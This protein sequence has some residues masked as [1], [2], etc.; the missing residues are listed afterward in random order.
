MRELNRNVTVVVD[1]VPFSFGPGPCPDWAADRISFPGVW[2]ECPD[3]EGGRP[4]G[5]D[6]K[7]VWLNYA[8]SLGLPVDESMTKKQIVGAVNGDVHID[9]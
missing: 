1:G 3:P 8:Q 2:V 6:P 9:R 4:S 5:S 7:A